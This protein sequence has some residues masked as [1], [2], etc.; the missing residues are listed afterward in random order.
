LQRFDL[1][2][3]GGALLSAV[4]GIWML[5]EMSA[6]KENAELVNLDK[7]NATQRKIYR[8]IAIFTTFFAVIVL[9]ALAVQRLISLGVLASSPTSEII[10]SFILYGVLA[11]NN[12]LA[13]ALTFSPA[14]TGFMTVI[15]LLVMGIIGL[16][17]VAAFFLDVIWRFVFVILD[18]AVWALFTP[19]IVIPYGIGMMFGLI[20]DDEDELAPDDKA[21]EE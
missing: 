21:E 19:I 15:F 6:D 1:A 11:I 20:N 9:I 2:I 17:P 18:V 5:I 8:I 4:V 16:L 13:A 12:S 7:L 14:A 10:L 3:L